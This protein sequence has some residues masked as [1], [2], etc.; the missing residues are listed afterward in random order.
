VFEQP[1]YNRDTNRDSAS[2]NSILTDV[3]KQ[4]EPQG[5]QLETS[6]E[7]DPMGGRHVVRVKKDG[8]YVGQPFRLTA[9]PNGVPLIN[10]TGKSAGGY[11]LT[12]QG[13]G[14]SL[15][16]RPG[17]AILQMAAN[18]QAYRASQSSRGPASSDEEYI[19]DE[20]DW[21]RGGPPVYDNGP[22]D[23]FGDD[24]GSVPEMPAWM[25]EGRNEIPTGPSP[26]GD[27]Q[28][29]PG[30]AKGFRNVLDLLDVG[31]RDNP[32]NKAV[33]RQINAGDYMRMSHAGR[34]RE[35]NSEGIVKNK[36]S[37]WAYPDGLASDY[38]PAEAPYLPGM[39][40]H[41]PLTPV[42]SKGTV[43]PLEAR[44][45]I[46][47]NIH[48]RE[49][50]PGGVE[51][52]YQWGSQKNQGKQIKRDELS[53]TRKY[54]SAGPA[55][56]VAYPEVPQHILGQRA[57]EP[58]TAHIAKAFILD[59]GGI[60]PEGQMWKDTNY[61]PWVFGSFEQNPEKFELRFDPNYSEEEV[62]KAAGLLGPDGKFRPRV[63][64]QGNSKIASPN[65]FKKDMLQNNEAG[66][67]S[68]YEIVDSIN[69]KGDPIKALR[70]KGYFG[71]RS[72]VILAMKLEGWKNLAQDKHIREQMGLDYDLIMA[73][74]SDPVVANISILNALP[75]DEFEGLWREVHGDKPAPTRTSNMADVEGLA[76]VWQ[77]YQDRNRRTEII[78]GRVFDADT[79]KNYLEAGI[80]KDGKY[81]EVPPLFEGAETM[82]KADLVATGFS[83]PVRVKYITDVTKLGRGNLSNEIL[84][85]VEHN[86]PGLGQHLRELGYQGR[87]IYNTLFEMHQLNT[88]PGWN[89][90]GSPVVDLVNELT[91]N[92]DAR[93]GIEALYQQKLAEILPASMQGV[94][95]Y[96]PDQKKAYGKFQSEAGAQAIRQ[97]YNDALGTDSYIFRMGLDDASDEVARRGQYPKGYKEA[98][99]MVN[100]DLMERFG[101]IDEETNEKMS[102]LKREG[103]Y[104]LKRVWEAVHDDP[105]RLKGLLKWMIKKQMPGVIANQQDLL[106]TPAARKRWFGTSAGSIQ[107]HVHASD[108]A[109]P[110]NSMAKSWDDIFQLTGLK[111][112]RANRAYLNKLSRSG[113]LLFGGL[114]NPA[115]H[116]IAQTG[117]ILNVLTP[118]LLQDAGLDVPTTGHGDIFHPHYVQ[119]QGGDNDSD[120]SQ[121]YSVLKQVAGELTNPFGLK[122]SSPEDITEGAK[123]HAAG[124]Y[125]DAVDKLNV[126]PEK[127][128]RNL[129]GF[130]PSHPRGLPGAGGDVVLDG[131]RYTSNQWMNDSLESYRLN[132]RQIGQAY[133]IPIRVGINLTTNPEAK[134][135]VSEYGGWMYQNPL[136][137]KNYEPHSPEEDL[138]SFFT[139]YNAFTGSFA[140]SRA[141]DETK[142]TYYSFRKN[143]GFQ[144]KANSA[145]PACWRSSSG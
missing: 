145:R 52:E 127:A 18:D 130:D 6:F 86:Y 1:T 53:L 43:Y 96:D 81:E 87:D 13:L 27:S 126:T 121:I 36:N 19:P 84:R 34:F 67:I 70:L 58:E 138:F 29:S 38:Q 110:R 137:K 64:K 103:D 141:T 98:A 136:D 106:Q 125:T 97:Y 33:W 128:R 25:K 142:G 24:E 54:W 143:R 63:L 122:P 55:L 62:L 48:G 8:D 108:Y 69:D 35:E 60:I 83:A 76:K 80:I 3:R 20:P 131:S 95:D 119:R 32:A 14:V 99:Y 45:F 144:N 42:V 51:I 57:T 40:E 39:V 139:S 112:T 133:N 85:S 101:Y 93:A 15:P 49:T 68:G 22:G 47:G 66:V 11:R 50:S 88:K 111:Q 92:K 26:F 21:M 129:L 71:N 46:A 105:G 77:L 124:E 17:S 89:E 107:T 123:R 113:Q 44:N 61:A 7:A 59:K 30:N 74:P 104:Q 115:S 56:G 134:K 140:P 135:R 73:K 109:L 102:D 114:R 16:Q 120:E 5:F 31:A 75:R 4:L 90:H 118:D 10:K 9:T 79:L 82:Y 12:R 78:P 117:A 2:I 132:S 116:P 91:G 94:T 37:Q 41:N 65:G 100:P 23:Y 28:G 72:N